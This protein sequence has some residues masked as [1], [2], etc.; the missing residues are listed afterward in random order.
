MIHIA[1]LATPGCLGSSIEGIKEILSLAN[2]LHGSPLFITKVVSVNGV[3]VQSYTGTMFT[4]DQ[5]LVGTKADLLI[6]PPILEGLD[7]LVE[8]VEITEWLV[9]HHE[10]GGRIA[11][12]CAGS[13]L[14][15]ETGLLN[16][17]EA[18]THW[19]LAE[20][21]EIRYPE[22]Q[23]QI[24]RL[25]IDGGDYICCGGVSA[26]MD[27]S[28]YL[29]TRFMGKDIARECAKIMLMDP[30][31]EHQTPY[32][33]G[34][35]RKNHNSKKI[36]KVQQ[37]IEDNYPE[38]ILLKDMA[39]IASLSERTFIRH[40]RAATGKPPAQYLQLV[41]IEAAQTLL[42]TTDLSVDGVAESIG[43]LD[44]SA[45]RKLFKR[46]MGCT[47]SAYRQHFGTVE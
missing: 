1:I 17:R 16:G 42:E 34:G 38:P 47:P 32:G 45:F 26:W 5:P 28:L 41:R 46:I 10:A 37:F 15:A 36:L 44:Y 23:L 20:M 4:P 31:R 18:T 27:L 21:F 19:N 12:V 30:Q 7:E 35:F 22:I 43:Y 33:M 11:A 3:S 6:L 29:L 14:L 2:S 39:A 40:F 24:H 9:R 25:L 8:V 13:F